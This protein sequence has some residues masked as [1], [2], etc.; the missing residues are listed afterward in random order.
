MTMLFICLGLGVA[1]LAALAV[2]GA[3]V[4]GAARTLNREIA[5]VHEQFRDKEDLKG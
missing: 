5:Q 4:V 3:R 2:A 1:G